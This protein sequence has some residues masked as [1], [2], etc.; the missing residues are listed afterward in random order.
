LNVTCSS[1]DKAEKELIEIPYQASIYISGVM[2]LNF[3]SYELGLLVLNA[4]F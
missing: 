4:D 2:P 1:Y 3:K